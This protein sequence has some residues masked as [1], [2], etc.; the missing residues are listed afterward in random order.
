MLEERK[1]ADALLA[2]DEAADAHVHTCMR[3]TFEE[4]MHA[5]LAEDEAADAAVVAA[6][7]PRE[8]RLAQVALR[9]LAVG[10]KARGE[11][12]GAR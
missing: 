11:R 5:L 12:E 7:G 10:G 2:E 1:L 8:R 6:V 9:A 3:C 4:A